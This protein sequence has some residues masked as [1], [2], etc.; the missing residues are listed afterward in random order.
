[1]L[2]LRRLKWSLIRAPAL[3]A[4]ENFLGKNLG[5]DLY[6][7]YFAD[8][9]TEILQHLYVP[10]DQVNSVQTLAHECAQNEAEAVSKVQKILYRGVRSMKQVLDDAKDRKA[11]ELVQEY[12]RREPSAVTLVH[13]LLAAAGVSMDR[14]MANALVQKLNDIERIDRLVTT[15]ESRRDASLHEIERRRAVLGETLRRSVQEIDDAE[16][17]EIETTPAQG[18]SAA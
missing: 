6:S 15:A 12:A 4:L 2:R 5:Y 1:V 7:Q 14:F 10:E 16:F 18:K 11:K 17:K 13:E 9:L 3:E 8:A